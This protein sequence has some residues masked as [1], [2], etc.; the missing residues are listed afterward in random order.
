MPRRPRRS[1]PSRATEFGASV[2]FAV[3]VGRAGRAEARWLLPKICD[4]GGITKDGIGAIRVQEDETFVQIAVADA[5]KFGAGME[6]EPGVTLR[7]IEG[8]PDLDAP[9]KP[10][11]KPREAK[12]YEGKAK[13]YVPKA[14]PDDH[15]PRAAAAPAPLPPSAPLRRARSVTTARPRPANPT[16]RT[17]S[18]MT[19]TAS[20]MPGATMRPSP[21]RSAP[22]ATNPP[23]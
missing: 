15:A 11:A 21:M 18:P 22:R 12:P 16:I 2:W 19:P 23:M 20:P 5:G 10:R 4:A 3:S 7:R 6:L 17:G 8:E 9:V 14:L 13:V 1:R